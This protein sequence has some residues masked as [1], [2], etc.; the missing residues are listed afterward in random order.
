MTKKKYWNKITKLKNY[1]I[2]G[3]PRLNDDWKKYRSRFDIDIK[4][5]RDS[6]LLLLG[7][8]NYVGLSEIMS[9]I[10]NVFAFAKNRLTNI[11]IKPHPRNINNSRIFKFADSLNIKYQISKNSVF[12]ESQKSNVMIST[13]KSSA[14]MDAVFNNCPVLEY[15]QYG[16]DKNRFLEFDYK[17]KL[18]SIYNYYGIVKNVYHDNFL[19]IINKIYDDDKYKRSLI[20]YQKSKLNIYLKQKQ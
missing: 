12:Y 7:K 10:E 13:S 15:F 9:I 17:G 5:K 8:Y 6:I 4:K 16:N 18:T 1:E 3:F 20:D 14:C 2:A 19:R 11:I